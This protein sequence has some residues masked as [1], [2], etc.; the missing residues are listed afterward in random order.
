MEGGLGAARSEAAELGARLGGVLARAAAHFT[1]RPPDAPLQPDADLFD[2]LLAALLAGP[3]Y[4]F[5]F[6]H[7]TTFKIKSKFLSIF[8]F[9]F[10]FPRSGRRQ[11][12]WR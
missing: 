11:R 9:E 3:C 1:T 2:R 8:L 7:F 6:C 5:M 12:K 4:F 10:E